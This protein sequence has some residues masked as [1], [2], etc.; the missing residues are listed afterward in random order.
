MLGVVAYFRKDYS[1]AYRHLTAYLKHFPQH[2]GALKLLAALAL[3]NGDSD[4]ALHLLEKLAPRAPQ[5]IEILTMY[6]DALMR[7]R[8]H[9][10]AIGVLEKAASISDPR[11]SALSRLVR[12]G[13]T[14]GQNA[15]AAKLLKT[16]MSRNPQAV[17][18][19]L[20]MAASQ[21]NQRA[22]A[23]AFETAASVLE[24]YPRNPVAH[25]LTGGA[26][27]GLNDFDAARRSFRAAFE[28]APKYFLAVS[29]LAKLEFRLG[30]L[31][32][33]ERLYT[34][35][36]EQDSRN[37]AAMMALSEIALLRGDLESALNWLKKARK[38]SRKPRLAALHLVD[39]YIFANNPEKALSIARELNGLEP[40]N[41]TFLTALGRA[42]LAANRIELAAITFKEIAVRAAEMKSADWL[43]RNVAWQMRALDE[44]GAR[45]SLQNA[46]KMDDKNLAAHLAFFKL[47]M[48]AGRIDAALARATMVI[49]LDQFSPVGD[50]LRGD[51]Y[52]RMGEGNV[53]PPV[54]IGSAGIAC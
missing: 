25:N 41:L 1:N 12:P 31:S 51:A 19:V 15:E 39:L 49:A 7:A 32:A 26:H 28:A 9:R 43:V 37:G 34:Y 3:S 22:Y 6:G 11:Y 52:M 24:R 33:A 48:A 14:A 5:D 30:N 38:K 45:K 23:L 4:Y 53:P 42:R 13:L 2:L 10:K 47:E 17:Q 54:E 20:L 8:R 40:A 21:L 27:V 35:M 16:E 29:N 18:A 46:L 44:Q 36:V 50:M